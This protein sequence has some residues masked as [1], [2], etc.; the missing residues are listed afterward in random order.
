[1]YC[2]K[3]G[4]RLQESVSSC[5]LCG[6][7][8][9]NPDAQAGEQSYPDTFPRQYQES[10][11]GYAVLMTV[12]CVIATVTILTVCFELYGHL[13]WGGY[14]IGGIA[15]FYLLAVLPSW[16]SHPPEE[17]FIPVDH[18][19]AALYTLYICE[20]TG[21]DWFL[22]FA[23]PL[24]GMSCILI[25]ALVC[26]LKY[27]KNGKPF[28]LGGFLI[29]L[30]GATVLAEFFEHLTFGTRMFQWSFY[31]L[32]FL[33]ASGIFLLI[34]GFVPSLRQAMRRYFFY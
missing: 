17:V 34:A 33:S 24:I 1:M 29:L 7:P 32:G 23:F 4:V 19:A 21:G 26:L 13:A 5:P 11:I 28:I 18:A 27:V 30:G 12:L 6:T 15:L 9:W 10:S 25:T 3:C 22:R 20:K 31:T 2:V 14:A 16:F 8:V